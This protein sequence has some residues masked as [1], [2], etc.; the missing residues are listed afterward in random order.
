[1][2]GTAPRTAQAA[3]R[4]SDIKLTMGVYTDEKHLAV[5]E[6]VERLPRL[7]PIPVTKSAHDCAGTSYPNGHSLAHA[8]TM[9]V[10]SNSLN[11]ER[12]FEEKP[13]SVNAKP[14]VAFTVTGGRGVEQKRFELDLFV[15][16][17]RSPSVATA[18]LRRYF[19]ALV[20]CDKWSL[21]G[22]GSGGSSAVRFGRSSSIC[23]LN[24]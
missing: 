20:A 21:E 23:A 19:K 14:P 12:R 1:M 17:E 16:N 24:D 18:P 4:H 22:R 2:T 11:N 15:A 9:G 13:C 10:P 7:A 8:D 6:A 5:R 3:M